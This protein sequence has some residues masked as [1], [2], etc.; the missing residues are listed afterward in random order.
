[1]KNKQGQS[2]ALI[3]SQISYLLLEAQ[4][5]EV[6]KVK[7]ESLLEAIEVMDMNI[8]NDKKRE[9]L[10]EIAENQRLK[11]NKIEVKYK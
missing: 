9:K 8:C 7:D 11:I 6:K 5:K 1:M 4:E 2:S 3:G 10:E